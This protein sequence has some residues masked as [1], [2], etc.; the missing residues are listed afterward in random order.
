MDQGISS[1]IGGLADGIN[2]YLGV[3]IEDQRAAAND[4]MKS[5]SQLALKQAES[6]LDINKGQKIEQYK[7]GLED[8]L[9]PD[10][11]EKALPGYG[12]KMVQDYNAQRPDNPLKLKDGIAFI[13]NAADTLSQK[14]EKQKK[15]DDVR[16]TQYART[17]SSDKEFSAVRTKRD[18]LENMGGLLDQVEKQ[19]DGPDKRQVMENAMGQV[20]VLLNSGQ[21]SESEIAHLMPDTF[22]GKVAAGLEFFTNKPEGTDAQEF[23]K[24]ARDFFHRE[25][26]I[27]DNQLSR[28]MNELSAPYK[29][30]LDRNED[31]AKETFSTYNVHHPKYN[32]KHDEKATAPRAGMTPPTED[33]LG[34][35]K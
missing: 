24:R 1:A 25:G 12:A 21:I 34:L 30:I 2:K 4:A 33:P 16:M 7:N 13:K 31:V 29:N 5:Q 9:T 11:A 28:R 6:S 15:S 19:P 18:N 35:F 17:L 14:S 8:V 26:T 20:R 22:R 32:P 23:V 3:R 10:M 27:T